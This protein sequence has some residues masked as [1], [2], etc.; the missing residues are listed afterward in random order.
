[1]MTNDISLIECDCGKQI[2]L[3]GPFKMISRSESIRK[4]NE[5]EI[6]IIPFLVREGM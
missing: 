6:V 3:S 2:G 5:E 1:M 4:P